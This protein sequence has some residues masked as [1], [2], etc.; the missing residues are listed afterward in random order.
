LS[1]YCGA[2]LFDVLG[3]AS[4]V[5]DRF[6]PGVPSPLDGLTLAE[7]AVKE[8]L[9]G[10]A[11]AFAIA[12]L[13]AALQAAG[14]L[15]DTFTGFA[16]AAIVDPLTGNQAAVIHHIYTM[17]GVAIFVAIGGDAW[18]IQGLARTYDAVPLLAM[19][20]L[21]ELVAGANDAFVSIFRAAVEVCAP[22]M[23]AL[24]LTDAAFGLVSRVVPQLNVFAVGF[25]VKIV[26]GLALLGV[27]L[28]FAADWF[29]DEL[30]ASVR[31]A[32]QTLRVA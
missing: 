9:V 5:V 15:L 1:G 29:Q 6:F 11:F 30:Q 23:I 12:A 27:T 3:L 10:L 18:V 8:I 22:V 28:P 19:P 26:V 25:P 4:S 7:L 21:G 13:F 32:L 17:I 14:S 24:I 20:N 31:A 16:Y 2:Q